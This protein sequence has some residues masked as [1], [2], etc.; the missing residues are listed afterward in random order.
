MA[1]LHEIGKT[2]KDARQKKGI[3]LEKIWNSTRIQSRIVEALETGTADNILSRVYVLLFLKKYAKLLDLDGAKLVED[4]KSFYSVPEEPVLVLDK[5]EPRES[6]IDIKKW[7]TVTA[8]ALGVILTVFLVLTVAIKVKSWFGARRRSSASLVASRATRESALP[9]SAARIF[10]I[11]KDRSIRLR[12]KSADNVWMKAWEDGRVSF[13]GTL[14]KNRTKN[15][16]A[17][18]S[19]RLWAGRTEVVTFIINGVD[20]GAIGRGNNKNINVSREGLKIGKKWLIRAK[21]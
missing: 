10:P 1:S 9:D 2:L 13:E 6:N 5:E 17:N 11:A 8:S 4:Y 18:K 7:I 16:T 12:L 19:I 20:I 21:K 15:F 14:E 3:T